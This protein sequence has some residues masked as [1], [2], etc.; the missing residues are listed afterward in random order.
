MQTW[1]GRE[2][3]SQVGG[4]LI[5]RTGAT[6]NRQA[7]PGG[8]TLLKIVAIGLGLCGGRIVD[9]FVEREKREPVKCFIPLNIN[10]SR[11][12]LASLTNIPDDSKLLIGESTVKG[13]GVS[14]DNKLGAKIAFEELDKIKNAID[15]AATTDIDAFLLVT[16]LGG[17][18]GGGAFPVVGKALDE[19]YDEPVYGLGVLP[20]S[21]EGDI[22]TLN[23]ARS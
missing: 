9:A 18:T 17:G 23:A 10:T 3:A 15:R 21:E 6:M 16:G 13:H 8:K 11:A 22:Y 12:D 19:A 20:A 7:F 4:K 5:Y 2:A 14:A 1:P